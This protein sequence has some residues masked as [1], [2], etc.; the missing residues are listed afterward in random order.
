MRIDD[1]EQLDIN[2]TQ[3]TAVNQVN[4]VNPVNPINF[5]QD[6]EEIE[7]LISDIKKTEN[8]LRKRNKSTKYRHCDYRPK[9]MSFRYLTGNNLNDIDDVVIEIESPNEY[10]TNKEKRIMKYT[11]FTTIYIINK[12]MLRLVNIIIFMMNII[13]N[14]VKKHN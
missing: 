14:L 1:F 9:E 11:D 6:M 12:F 2:H 7:L 13:I 3:N 4:P 10:Y 5:E 8:T